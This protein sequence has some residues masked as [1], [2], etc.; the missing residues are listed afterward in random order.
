MLGDLE[1]MNAEEADTGPDVIPTQI[2]D[3]IARHKLSACPPPANVPPLSLTKVNPQVWEAL[4]NEERLWD[5]EFQ[6]CLHPVRVVMRHT[7]Y[8]LNRQMVL[9]QPSICKADAE[10]LVTPAGRVGTPGIGAED[11]VEVV[12]VVKEAAESTAMTNASQGAWPW[13]WQRPRQAQVR[14]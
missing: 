4:F 5:V 2:T 7:A 3:K 14:G 1:T 13:L 10:D 9:E 11:M 6:K 12:H 8:A